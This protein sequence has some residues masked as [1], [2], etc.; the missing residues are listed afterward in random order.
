MMRRMQKGFMNILG[1][2]A[3]LRSFSLRVSRDG[4]GYEWVKI[5][6]NPPLRKGELFI[7]LLFKGGLGWIF[8]T[9]PK[10]ES[11]GDLPRS[12]RWFIC[13]GRESLVRFKPT[14]VNIVT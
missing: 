14:L 6:L 3:H 9:F 11:G 8:L 4:T 5:P 12:N 10:G 13:L 1:I 2:A 7:S